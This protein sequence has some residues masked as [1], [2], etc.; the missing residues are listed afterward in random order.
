MLS[1]ILEI[2][3]FVVGFPKLLKIQL[4]RAFFF[5]NA[6]IGYFLKILETT[7]VAKTQCMFTEFMCIQSFDDM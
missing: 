7:V 4:L 1:T 3:V 5:T 6:K 2:H